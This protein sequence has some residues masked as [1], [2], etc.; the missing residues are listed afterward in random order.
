MLDA[1][2]YSALETLRNGRSV[3][4]R[5]FTPRDKDGLLA[6]VARTSALSLYRRFFAIKRDFTE[7]EKDFF[8]NVDFINHV[9][10][11]AVVEE[12]AGPAIVGGARYV[13]VRPGRAEVAF[14][15]IDAHQG[16]GIGSA[17]M[18]HLVILARAAGLSE[19]IAE[20]LPENASMLKVFET[21][22]LPIRTTHSP[23]AVHVVLRLD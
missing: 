17:L 22:G 3:Q 14:V 1:A 20:V 18:R 19:L 16:Q 8:L 6:A 2:R 4:I 12:E 13:M 9:A 5:A 7:R 23:E 10:L 15:V 21:C 11:M